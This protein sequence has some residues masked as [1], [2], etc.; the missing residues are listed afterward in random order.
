MNTSLDAAGR[1]PA[2]DEAA[3]RAALER[4]WQTDGE[5]LPGPFRVSARLFFA[6]FFGLDGTMVGVA[7]DG[8]AVHRWASSWIAGLDDH[9][10]LGL[11]RIDAGRIDDDPAELVGA[12]R[13]AALGTV[14]QPERDHDEV[15]AFL[16][17][18]ARIPADGDGPSLVD[19]RLKLR[20][21][22]VW[23]LRFAYGDVIYQAAIDGMTGTV[24]HAR[25]P[26]KQRRRA[27]LGVFAA[28]CF[29][30]VLGT[31]LRHPR[32][33]LPGLRGAIERAD[34]AT[35]LPPLAL[36]SVGA[37]LYV[38]LLN[39]AWNALRYRNELVYNSGLKTRVLIHRQAETALDRTTAG[40]KALWK[41][42]RAPRRYDR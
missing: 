18:Q 11:T 33:G 30:Y 9:D 20:F 22:P 31:M 23:R 21:C 37:A 13:L 36:A 29:G 34:A 40:L 26:A 2:L 25:V 35:L 4:V 8:R 14:L 27:F 39:A 19:R 32:M 28:A 41:R 12:G 17:E 5:P 3:A 16:G 24:L 6:P 7:P 1:P 15:A 38:L 10:D 42:L